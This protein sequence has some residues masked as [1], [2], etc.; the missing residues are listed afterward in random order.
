MYC[1]DGLKIPCLLPQ[2]MYSSDR[3]K[4]NNEIN[5]MFQKVVDL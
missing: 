2:H 3:V 1:F 5:G 4:Y